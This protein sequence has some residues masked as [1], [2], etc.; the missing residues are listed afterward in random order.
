MI[1]LR[2]CQSDWSTTKTYWNDLQKHFVNKSDSTKA[3]F[4]NDVLFA[5]VHT[6]NSNTTD[7]PSVK[8]ISELMNEI[9]EE[10]KSDRKTNE[11]AQNDVTDHDIDKDIK[12][13]VS[14]PVM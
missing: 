13:F 9:D 5:S 7:I 8:T 11:T 6:S 10:S 1:T 3:N 4:I 14:K 12:Q 2:V